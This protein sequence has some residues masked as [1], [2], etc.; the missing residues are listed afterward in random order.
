MQ[1]PWQHLDYAKTTS[2]QIHSNSSSPTIHYILTTDSGVKYGLLA[3]G[4]VFDP[5]NGTIFVFSSASTP[6][7]G[8][9]HPSV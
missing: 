6:A 9:T 7:P 8:H 3:G 1:I 2:F 4:P 5:G